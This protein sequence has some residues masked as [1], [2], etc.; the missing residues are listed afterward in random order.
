MTSAAEQELADSDETCGCEDHDFLIQE[1]SR[2][3]NALWRYDRYIVSAHWCDGL[4]E[5]WCDMKAQEQQ[6]I[7]RLKKL[8]AEEL[9]NEFF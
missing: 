4:L 8:L 6:N 1:L 3:L 5:F 9:R 7:R 2:R